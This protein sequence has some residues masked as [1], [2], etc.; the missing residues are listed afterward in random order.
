MD[1]RE[2]RN[3][4]LE[5]I[6]AET[7]ALFHAGQLNCA[8][9]ALRILSAYWGLEG[10]FQPRIATAFGGGVCGSQGLCGA[11][12]GALMAV[13]LKI[14]RRHPGGDKLPAYQEGR[15][16]LNWFEGQ[17]GTVCCRDL[18]GMDTSTPEAQA[19]FRAPG[20]AHETVCERI[21]PEICRHLADKL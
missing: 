6:I 2:E 5:A 15:A 19:L 7:G 18:T 9:A 8:E 20:G 16:L 1:E 3:E 17:K 14:G 12:T 10:D 11:L 21:V 4:R 13:G